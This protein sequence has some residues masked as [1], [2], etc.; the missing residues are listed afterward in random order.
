MSKTLRELLGDWVDGR[1]L[2]ECAALLSVSVSTLHAWLHG[3]SVPRGRLVQERLAQCLGVPL[4]QLDRLL[5]DAR[6][7]RLAR[8]R[9]VLAEAEQR[10]GIPL[11]GG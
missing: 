6:R 8:A 10:A 3:A 9:S 4:D 11:V 5:E 1:P 2:A 7:D